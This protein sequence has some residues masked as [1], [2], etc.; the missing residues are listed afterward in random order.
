MYCL[1]IGPLVLADGFR[2]VHEHGGRVRQIGR[3]RDLLT[4][5]A[6]TVRA[7]T[8]TTDD[9]LNRAHDRHRIIPAAASVKMQAA[10]P[11]ARGSAIESGRDGGST[12]H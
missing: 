7:R 1:E 2:S 5:G 6:R 8:Q 9:H 10:D 12:G 4:H 11:P 3:R